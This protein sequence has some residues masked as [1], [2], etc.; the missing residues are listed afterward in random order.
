[1]AT[2]DL[3]KRSEV[4]LRATITGEELFATTV[5]KA[6]YVTSVQAVASYAVSN[7]QWS[8]INGRPTTYPPSAHT[9]LMTEVYG[10]N[11]ALTLKVDYSALSAVALSGSYNDLLDKPVIPDVDGFVEETRT[12]TAGAGLTGGGD[13]SAN[14]TLALSSAAQASLGLANTAVQPG[15][16]GDLALL[17]VLPVNKINA[18]GTPSDTNVLYG[19]GTWRTPAGGGDLYSENNLSDLTDAAEARDNLGLGDLA[20]KDTVNNADW[21]G[22]QLSI[23][24][25]GTG[26]TTAAAAR[27][28]LGLGTAATQA[29]TAF[30]TAAQGALA[31]T[32]VQPGDLGYLATKDSVAVGDIDATG[33]PGA[34]NFLRG[35]GSWAAAG[36]E[37]ASAAEIRLGTD[38]TKSL[39]VAN[40]WGAVS[41]VTPIYEPLGPQYEVYFNQ[42]I[43]FKF[44]LDKNS[45]LAVFGGK[46]GQSGCIV[47]I[48]DSTGS[49]TLS[50]SSNMHFADG[51]PS[52]S[53]APGAVDVIV[54][55]TLEG[56]N[57]R[58][59]FIKGT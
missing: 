13:L 46:E 33:T 48:Q 41:W 52:L 22:T 11:D 35:D 24:N 21:S 32:A 2:I 25:G 15:D 16:L 26:A 45:I 23:A 59:V 3:T 40:T 12:I 38:T 20:V 10:L 8:D 47:I 49:R 9:H 37:L 17:D 54:Y 18:T 39:G 53:T 14:R 27:T 6:L 4:P 34:G 7:V 1:M 58:C 19:D 44:T 31:N 29:S 51:V 36:G 28:N 43:N 30:A 5:G 50:F 57:H 42:G 56:G 55:V